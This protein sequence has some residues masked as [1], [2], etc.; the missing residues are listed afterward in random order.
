MTQ[1]RKPGMVR[2][3]TSKEKQTST[4]AL[5]FRLV[6]GWHRSVAIASSA[7]A[8]RSSAKATSLCSVAGSVACRRTSARGSSGR[9]E[10]QADRRRFFAFMNSTML[11]VVVSSSFYSRTALIRRR[12]RQQYRF[13]FFSFPSGSTAE[14][15][16]RVHYT[17]R[18]PRE[19]R[20][21]P[22]VARQETILIIQVRVCV[23]P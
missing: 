12:V 17:T 21:P 1:P 15:I 7:A 4:T 9:S 10:K 3:K 19:Y 11:T 8:F 23:S 16:I 6:I 22:L 20:S 5:P 18:T 13:I 14:Y 2:S